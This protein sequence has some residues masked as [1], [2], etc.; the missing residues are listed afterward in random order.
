MSCLLSR[1][2]YSEGMEKADDNIC[3]TCMPVLATKNNI[4]NGQGVTSDQGHI[5]IDFIYCGVVFVT[6][7]LFH[8][9]M[10]KRLAKPAIVL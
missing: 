8:L 10:S 7:G 4:L 5:I 3:T 2:V 6:F 1:L 9:R